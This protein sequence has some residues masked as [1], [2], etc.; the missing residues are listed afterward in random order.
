M[1]KIRPILTINIFLLLM[2]Q[3]CYYNQ[4]EKVRIIKFIRYIPFEGETITSVARKFDVPVQDIEAISKIPD[5]TYLSTTTLVRI[6]QNVVYRNIQLEKTAATQ[7]AL[8]IE[9]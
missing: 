9:D 4:Y 1:K 6:P 5:D 3:G 2:L 7:T 8:N